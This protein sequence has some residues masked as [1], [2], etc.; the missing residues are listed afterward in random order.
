MKT[1]LKRYI[2]LNI[3]IYQARG[4][5]AS[6]ITFKNFLLICISQLFQSRGQDEK[7][8]KDSIGAYLNYIK[9]K[10]RE[11]NKPQYRK[12]EAQ[13]TGIIDALLDE[14][15]QEEKVEEQR[16]KAEKKAKENSQGSEVLSK[17]RNTL[18]I[19]YENIVL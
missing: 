3:Y 5:N 16:K 15:E 13:C 7:N 1:L 9:G 8:E 14:Q 6:I 2:Y 11:L 19:Y 4:K 17:I 10:L 12:F 18:K